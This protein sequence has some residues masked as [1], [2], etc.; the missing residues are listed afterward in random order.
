MGDPLVIWR[1]KDERGGSLLEVLVAFVLLQIGLLAV[2]PLF[3]W[4][5]RS[6]ATSANVG[7]LAAAATEQME[8][9]KA[10][11]WTS[12]AAGGSVDTDTTGFVAEYDHFKVRWAV[13]ESAPDERTL[14]VRAISEAG[15]FTS[16]RVTLVS[17]R[18]RS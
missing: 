6:N 15:A 12:L 10:A 5:M 2:A 1:A 8:M 13:V 18:S 16:K 9:L 17:T 11:P 14:R 7:R 3:V 4:A